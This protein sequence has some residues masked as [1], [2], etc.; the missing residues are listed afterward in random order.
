MRVVFSG[1]RRRPR[2]QGLAEFALVVPM[3]LLILF[4]TIQVGVT[5]GGY[6]GLINSVRE[7]ARYGSVCTGPN[8]GQLTA[9]RLISGIQGGVFGL[10]SG[11]ATAVVTYSVDSDG[12]STPTYS[13]KITVTGCLKGIVFIPLVGNILNWTDPSGVA[14]KSTA[15]FRVE[16][17]PLS[18]PPILPSPYTSPVG[19]TC[20]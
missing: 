7:A 15:V 4:G 13:T 9:T 12:A 19:G 10:K 16:G 8:C 1:T 2:G 20:P 18:A 6:N 11:T 17:Q 3:L 5:F 14:L